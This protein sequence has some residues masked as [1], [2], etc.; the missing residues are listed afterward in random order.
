MAFPAP[1]SPILPTPCRF[2]L[3]SVGDGLGA[4]DPAPPR[5][6]FGRMPSV[7]VSSGRVP[8]APIGSARPQLVPG[9]GFGNHAATAAH[10]SRTMTS[11]PTSVDWPARLR[12]RFWA[13]AIGASFE[14]LSCN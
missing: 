4:L 3:V 6:G 12:S 2:R 1:G 10:Y 13:K 7:D 14:R 11:S 9:W 5:T 8:R